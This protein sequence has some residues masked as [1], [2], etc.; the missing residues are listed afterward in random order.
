MLIFKKKTEVVGEVVDT[1][2]KGISSQLPHLFRYTANLHK[3]DEDPYTSGQIVGQLITSE[4]NRLQS[5]INAQ[6][7]QIHE[8]E[9]QIN[10]LLGQCYASPTAVMAR[11]MKQVEQQAVDFQQRLEKSQMQINSLENQIAQIQSRNARQLRQ[12]NAQLADYKRLNARQHLEL[13]DLMG[14]SY[15]TTNK[16]QAELP[17]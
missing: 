13:V 10:E 12:L 5:V 2:V 14:D 16:K 11:E 4:L 9:K 7:I 15:E 3:Q 8:Q 6:K 1:F 17:E